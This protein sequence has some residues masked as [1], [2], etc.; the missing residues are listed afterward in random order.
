MH[1]LDAYAYPVSLA[2]ERGI[3]NN[4]HHRKRGPGV[5]ECLHDE[6]DGVWCPGWEAPRV[7]EESQHGA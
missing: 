3:C 6:G 1:I 5:L 7:Q 4:C 2:A